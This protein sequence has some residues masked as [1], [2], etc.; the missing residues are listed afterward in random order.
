MQGCIAPRLTSLARNDHDSTRSGD[1]VPAYDMPEALPSS[2][3]PPLTGHSGIYPRAR[4]EQTGCKNTF[5][6]ESIH[7]ACTEDQLASIDRPSLFIRKRINKRCGG[8]VYGARSNDKIGPCKSAGYLTGR[9]TIFEYL[10]SSPT[11]P[12]LPA[13]PPSHSFSG[14]DSPAI[15]A[16]LVPLHRQFFITSCSPN[17]LSFRSFFTFQGTAGSVP[18]SS[19]SFLPK[20]NKARTRLTRYRSPN[21]YSLTLQ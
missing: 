4:C 7:T 20:D 13:V 8:T 1:K 17:N 15:P 10:P 9:R 19:D 3:L 14:S 21:K 16:P 6:L 12:T 11:L 2:V 5:R 18:T